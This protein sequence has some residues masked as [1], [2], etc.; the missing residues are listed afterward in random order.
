[1]RLIPIGFPNLSVRKVCEFNV[2]GLWIKRYVIHKLIKKM[3][4]EK[5]E[6]DY[7]LRRI[8][9]FK[10]SALSS[11]ARR[12]QTFNEKHLQVEENGQATASFR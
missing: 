11:R 6:M 9:W 7:G 2:S 1:M 10:H 8:D 3:Q 12:N 5:G 4:N